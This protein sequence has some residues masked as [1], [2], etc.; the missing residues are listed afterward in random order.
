M[1]M[2]Y[3]MFEVDPPGSPGVAALVSL[4]PHVRYAA[5][6]WGEWDVVARVDA[7]NLGE[8]AQMIDELR[9]IRTSARILRTET[10]LIR[11]DQCP[12]REYDYS[13]GRLKHAFVL[14]RVSDPKTVNISNTIS[15]IIDSAR[16]MGTRARVQSIAGVLG[17]YDIASTVTYSEEEFLKDLVMDTLQN[18]L[19]TEVVKTRTLPAVWPHIYRQGQMVTEWSEYQLWH[20]SSAHRR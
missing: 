19:K 15:N 18:E 20:G 13:H 11:E 7:S 17:T 9:R 1:S 12:S 2:A 8:L 5:A 4:R 10:L 3:V 6:V 16:S 14:F